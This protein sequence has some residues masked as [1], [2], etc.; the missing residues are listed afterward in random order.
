MVC[1]SWI[2]RLKILEKFKLL[3]WLACHNA[4]SA[5]S[6][7]HHRHI[8]AS[9]T[10]SRCVDEEETLLHFL[11]DCNHSKNSCHK[12]GFT[13]Q[14]FYIED[15]TSTWIKSHATGARS[16]IF[17]ADLWWMSRN[18]N[19]MCLSAESWSLTQIN[20]HVQ[21]TMATIE[22]ALHSEAIPH[23]DCMVCW[24]NFWHFVSWACSNSPWSSSGHKF[25]Y[26][27]N[28]LLLGFHALH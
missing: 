13:A 12:I 8:A 24:N 25:R 2:W 9:A 26:R 3:V 4:V 27:R 14:E 18:R 21:N 22:T 28:G 7:L 17:Q 19:Q 23:P 20:F 15:T 1:W 6:L 10:C 16:T 11:R 5:L